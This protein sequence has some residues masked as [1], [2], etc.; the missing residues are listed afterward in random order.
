MRQRIVFPHFSK[1][2]KVKF[3]M[4]KQI[5]S[6]NSDFKIALLIALVLYTV[7]LM[8]YSGILHSTD[9]F[10]ALAVTE[11][12]V[13]GRALDTKLA[14]WQQYGVE[15]AAGVQ[16]VF[17]EE[18]EL[19]SKRGLFHSLLPAPMFAL[20]SIFD[21]A[22]GRVHLALLTTAI[23][24]ALT[25]ALVYLTGRKAGYESVPAALGALAF[26]LATSA[27]PYARY[28]FG[29]PYIGLGLALAAYGVVRA[30][31]DDEPAW[32]ALA[33]AGLGLGAGFNL[34][35]LAVTPV[36][37]WAAW[38]GKRERRLV[39]LINTLAPLVL[40]LALIG[41]F[42]L[43]RFDSPLET[44]RTPGVGEWF[45]APVGVTLPA[46]L[47][48]PA[49]GLFWYSP[50]V[51]LGLVW[52]TRTLV[53]DRSMHRYGWYI[54]ASVAIYAV[55][56]S[57]WYMWWGGYAW[58][59]RFLV[60]L[61]PLIG[62]A[63]LPAI[64]RAYERRGGWR[65]TVVGVAGS[66]ISIQLLGITF[67]FGGHELMLT[68]RFGFA[69]ANNLAYQYGLETLYDI[70]LSPIIAHAQRLLTEGIDDI[71][72]FTASGIDWG[73]LVSLSLFLLLLVWLLSRTLAGAK[74]TVEPVAMVGILMTGLTAFAMLR[75][76][77]HPLN[78]MYARHPDLDIVALKAQPGDGALVYVPELTFSILNNYPD[79]PQTWG[80]P[81]LV[82]PNPYLE[83]ALTT[84]QQEQKRLW[85]MSW[86]DRLDPDAWAEARLAATHYALDIR[87]HSEA[88]GYWI[89]YYLM[90]RA[91]DD[92]KWRTVDWSLP[93]GMVL[94]DAALIPTEPEPGELLRLSLRWAATKA[95]E[96]DYVI[97]VHVVDSEGVVVAQFDHAPQNTFRPTW[98]WEP[99]ETIIDRVALRVP[100]GAGEYSVRVGMY[101][102]QE[103]AK[104]LE[105]K[106]PDGSRVAAV[107]LP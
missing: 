49:R 15:Y 18:G 9:A 78:A 69:D 20:G 106:L 29:E 24:T 26:G 25:G 100:E 65:A 68:R 5:V 54:A 91:I 39:R 99:G 1:C 93:E 22:M 66:A 38:H 4:A 62:L 72:W 42:N 51:W 3:N 83:D 60:S 102:W 37:L 104:L 12:L 36:V 21:A 85:V 23:V 87:R 50:L 11:N 56:Y 95:I 45:T 48:S 43:L 19:H 52:G 89:G 94:Q 75:N 17:T 97:F 73:I 88:G 58:G 76:A 44:G 33:G 74:M 30:Q 40:A 80:L 28:L 81:P 13:N 35:S 7:Y 77:E 96:G 64:D 34:G 90:R 6:N 63:A 105:G 67:D 79:F 2:T 98:T 92:E 70:K 101:D 55:V 103:P 61:S 32:L 84:A 46:M 27:W 59:P 47:F 31:T 86:F 71:S 8:T 57:A 14:I 53:R 16:G 10:S 82:D 107:Q 41:G